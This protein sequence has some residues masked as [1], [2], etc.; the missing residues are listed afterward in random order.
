MLAEQQRVSAELRQL[1][2]T[3][4]QRV[5]E[6]ARELERT[7]ATLSF[8][9]E[10]AG[11]GSWDLDLASGISHRSPEHDRLFGYDT[12]P[13]HWGVATF[14]GHVL[15]EDRGLAEGAYEGRP[16]QRHAGCRMP[17]PPRRWP[18]ALDRQARTRRVQPE[19]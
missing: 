6:R 16:A 13:A 12:P 9:L 1:N 15:P 8:A 10:A 19:W 7:Q 3:L 4:E 11:M 14:L 17:Y 5:E 18:G 2:D